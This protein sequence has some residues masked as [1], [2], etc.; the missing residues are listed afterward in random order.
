MPS[1]GY[2]ITNILSEV[3]EEKQWEVVKHINEC[4]K[5]ATSHGM[6]VEWLMSFLS[7]WE[8][9]KDPIISANAGLDEWDM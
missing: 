6:L 8:E 7:A 4:A 5:L 9:T 1:S 2:G 3:P